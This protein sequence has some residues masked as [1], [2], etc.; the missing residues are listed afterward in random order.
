MVASL[1]G[2]QDVFDSVSFSP[3]G[4]SA[5]RGLPAG[6]RQALSL[7]VLAG[8]ESASHVAGRLG[9]SRKFVAC[10]RDK[11]QAAL[12]R[13]FASETWEQEVLFY[14]PITPQW[15]RRF[16]LAEVLIGHAS[17]RGVRELSEALL[18]RVGPSLG[19]IHNILREAAARS[20]AINRQEELS[21]IRVAAFDE[22]YQSNRPTL[23]GMDLASTYC[24]LM[25]PEAACDTESW[26]YHLLE[27]S[28][29]RGLRLQRSIADGGKSL[30]AAHALVWPHL[31]CNGDVFHAL[32]AFGD[33]VQFAENRAWAA[34]R[35]IQKLSKRKDRN[36]RRAAPTLQQRQAAEAAQ[37]AAIGLFDDLALLF[38][39]LRT[40]VLGMAGEPLAV[41]EE[42]Y[43]FIVQELQARQALCPHRLRPL[44]RT[45]RNQRPV[46]L[47]FVRALEARLAGLAQEQR[48]PLGA[49]QAVCRLE[50]LDKNQ[51]LYWQRRTELIRRWGPVAWTA[52][53]RAVRE[54]LAATPR[55]SSLVENLNGRLRSYFF[56]WRRTNRPYLELL[57]FYLNH[58]PYLR[59]VHADRVGKSPYELLSGRAHPFWLD[60]LTPGR[61]SQDN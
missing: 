15:V 4:R 56:L 51:S 32:R 44:V 38:E 30:R 20:E 36:G 9:V 35:M 33:V 24:F 55:A 2:T 54:A 42:L 17:D 45:L 14:L 39:W 26:G 34:L 57:R 43:D 21:A 31:P 3:D 23:V 49:V 47:G 52:L 7:A 11:A 27:L 60:L 6:Q 50:A 61:P 53:E 19:T 37:T 22:I 12:D 46:L 29:R 59:S 13:A 16:V 1:I 8:V 41:R 40:D 10:Q 18:G 28:E 25:A 58:R 48:V 5:A